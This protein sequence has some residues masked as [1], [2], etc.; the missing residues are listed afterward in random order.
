MFAGYT[1]IDCETEINECMP[2][3]CPLSAT[4]IDQINGYYCRCPFNMT[5]T[6]CDKRID[7]DYDLRFNDG[8]VAA[9][10]ALSVPFHFAS[11][12]FS[13]SLWVRFDVAHSK[14]N[15][16]TLYHSQ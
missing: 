7:P 9:K 15:V 1:G 2:S 6:S 13:L 3:P 4:C 5:G 10:A 8:I 11:G 16:L 12:A 14:G